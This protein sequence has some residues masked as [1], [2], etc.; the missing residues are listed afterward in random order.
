MTPWTSWPGEGKRIAPPPGR[1]P[2]RVPAAA[3]FLP[4]L[5]LLLS[6]YGGA[7]ANPVDPPSFISKARPAPGSETYEAVPDD[8]GPGGGYAYPW[9]RYPR[10]S[11]AGFDAADLHFRSSLS[12]FVSDTETVEP[13]LPEFLTDPSGNVACHPLVRLAPGL[14]C[15]PWADVDSPLHALMSPEGTGASW[16][17]SDGLAL[18]AF[19]RHRRR[20]DG[21]ASG[22]FS[23]EGGSS[24]AAVHLDRT[25]RLD[26]TGRWRMRG[27]FVLAADLPRGFGKRQASPLEAGP[28]LLSDWSIG[29]THAARNL[30]TRLAL[31]QPPHAETGHG[32]LTLPS[33]R[34]QNLKRSH[35]THRFSLVPPRR[36]LT[37][38]LS[39]QRPL[40]GGDVVISL[41]RTQKQ[42][43]TQARRRYVAGI[44]WRKRF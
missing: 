30:H 44:A 22:A 33:G 11:I 10:L 25:W 28:A 20:P 37:L 18:S 43:H 38:R 7:A 41:L 29:V 23:F 3:R 2:G 32:T 39:H 34:F 4:A 6:G 16:F 27:T 17:F 36:Q 14:V 13:E 5:A 35:E 15:S 40:A 1:T 21:A 8:T 12:D 31:S 42:S 24:L 26:A 19:T 9:N